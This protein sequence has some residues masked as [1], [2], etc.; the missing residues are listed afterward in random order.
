MTTYVRKDGTK[1]RSHT[2]NAHWARSKQAMASAGFAGLSAFAIV[3]EAGFTLIST[4]AI[5]LIAVLTA[6]AVWAGHYASEN[7]KTME[8][9]RRTRARSRTSSRGRSTGSRRTS[10]R[11]SSGRRRR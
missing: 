4:L 2:R 9:Q 11:S 10:H 7:K 5:M 8:R 1:V 6:L 3:L